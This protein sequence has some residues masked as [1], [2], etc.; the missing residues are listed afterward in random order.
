MYL[1]EKR[2]QKIG[3]F[4]NRLVVY[5]TADEAKKYDNYI[6]ETGLNK[7]FLAD[8]AI[9]DF[10]NESSNHIL[11]ENN[12]WFLSYEGGKRTNRRE[13][14]ISD[15]SDAVLDIKSRENKVSRSSLASQAIMTYIDNN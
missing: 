3:T 12:A 11:R 1:T 8:R 9:K 7:H 2:E 5:F 6:A 10:V 13:V 15:I 14:S 4:K